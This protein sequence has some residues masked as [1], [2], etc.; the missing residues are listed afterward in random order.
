MSRRRF[1]LLF[2]TVGWAAAA[3]LLGV[4]QPSSAQ[5]PSGEV[6]VSFHVTLAPFWFDPSTAPPQITPFEITQRPGR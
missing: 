3:L 4:A 6:T 1:H 2:R 5:G